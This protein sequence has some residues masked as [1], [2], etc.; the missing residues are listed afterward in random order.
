MCSEAWPPSL[1]GTPAASAWRYSWRARTAPRGGPLLEEG[2]GL[3]A[4][5]RGGAGTVVVNAN[6]AA[7]DAHPYPH[8]ACGDQY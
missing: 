3:A 5:G 8:Q 6:T 2:L 4:A 1:L 7:L